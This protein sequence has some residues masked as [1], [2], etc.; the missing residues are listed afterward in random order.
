MNLAKAWQ[1]AAKEILSTLRDRRALVSSLLIPLLILPATML[2]LPLVLGG[3]FEREQ[4]TV[5]EVAVEG[6]AFLPDDLRT[7]F[8]DENVTLI[9]T[10]TPEQDV[11]EG[12]VQLALSV[13]ENL[14]ESLENQE[15]V[16][17]T[18]YSKRGN[19]RS[20]LNAG[21]LTAAV[22]EFRRAL[23]AKR[24]A[25]VGLGPEVLEPIVTETVDASTK[26]E[27][28]SGQFGWLVPF[29]IAIWTLVG[30]QMT[31]IDATAGEKERGTL[32]ALLVAPVGRAE[33]VVG[34]FLATLTFGLSAALMA[35]IGYLLSGALLKR[36]FL[37]QLGAEGEEIAALLGG[38]FSI[39]FSTI[40]MLIMSALLLAALIAA[41]LLSITMFARSFKEAQTYVA[42]LSFLL[43]VPVM[44]LQFA[45][46]FSSNP[47]IYLVPILNAM[48]LMNDVV[49]GDI[50]PLPVLLTWGSLLALSALCLDFAYRSFKREGV[51]FRT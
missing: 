21:K 12:T 33:V 40:I 48:L 25:D 32:E 8:E 47:L 35:I 34:K 13:P 31:A 26:T 38:S 51:I 9:E 41:L 5:T 30:G 16:S 39:S 43:I 46:F 42:P 44:G 29:F 36:L 17:L 37:P 23:V 7:A 28:E 49:K 14:A 3:L 20:E 27:R 22:A 18:L 10:T 11:R 1:V 19:L 15:K 2:G 24:L 6:L 4:A 50:S 45:D